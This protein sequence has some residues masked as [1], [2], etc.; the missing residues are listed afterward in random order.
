MARLRRSPLLLGLSLAWAGCSSGKQTGAECANDRDCPAK[1]QRCTAGACVAVPGA[2]CDADADCGAPGFCQI[3]AGAE[4][5]GGLCHYLP[6]NV[7]VSCDDANPCTLDDACDGSGRCTGALT[8]CTTPPPAECVG[9]NDTFRQYTSPGSCDPTDGECDYSYTDSA[10]INCAHDCLDPCAEIVCDDTAGGCRLSAGL[11]DPIPDPV[12]CDYSGS[13]AATDD[14]PCLRPGDLVPGGHC[15]AGEC[16]DCT[17]DL[18]CVT[19][20]GDPDCYA[21]ECTAPFCT[22]TPLAEATVCQPAGCADGAIFVERT[23]GPNRTCPGAEPVSCNGFACADASS[24]ATTCSAASGCLPDYFCNDPTAGDACLP[25]QLDGGSCAGYGDVACLSDHCGGGLCCASGYCCLTGAECWVLV[26]IE[27]YCSAPATC[28]GE[29]TQVACTDFICN[30]TAVGDDSFCAGM[31]AADCGAFRDLFCDLAPEQPTPVC[32]TDC[33]GDNAACDD[34]FYCDGA[35]QCAAQLP[36][37]GVSCDEDGDCA[38]THCDLSAAGSE[39]GRCCATTECCDADADCPAGDQCV[40]QLDGAAVYRCYAGANGDPCDDGTDCDAGV[41][42]TSGVCGTLLANGATGC[43]ANVDCASGHCDLSTGGAETGR[44]CLAG[45]C[46]AADAACPAGWQCVDQL[47][48]ALVYR[49]FNGETSASCDDDDDCDAGYHCRES[50]DLCQSGTIGQGCDDAT[51]CDAGA[52]CS[53][54]SICTAQLAVG[55]TT[56]SAAAQCSSNYCDLSSTGPETGR[57]CGGGQCCDADADCPSGDQCVDLV[58]STATYGCLTGADGQAC[59]D[60]A[61]CDVGNHCRESTN[62]CV[63]GQP[64]HGCDDDADCDSPY[65]CHTNL[66]CGSK[67]S[68]G[69]TPCV[70]DSQ[71]SSGHCDQSTVQPE[72]GRCC[73]GECCDE[74]TDCT[75]GYRCVEGIDGAPLNLCLSGGVGVW[76]DI[77]ADCWSPNLCRESTNVCV[78][79]DLGSPCDDEGD[80]GE[81]LWCED[82]ACQIMLSMGS[83][84]CSQNEGCHTGYCDLSTVGSERYRCCGGGECCDVYG[85][86]PSGYHCIVTAGGVEYYRCYA[87]VTGSPCNTTYGDGNCDPGYHCRASTDRCVSG[88]NGSGCDDNLDCDSGLSCTGGTCG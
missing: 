62:L 4:C 36:D 27:G 69:G 18:H 86:C 71:C 20:P 76:C 61:D 5:Y 58:D 87:G 65:V 66:Q 79:G 30:L 67:L 29:R 32:P 75:A 49:C 43:A 85:D 48:G 7:G 68:T 8:P 63:T 40:D 82:N 22:Y 45:E 57:C 37:G 70:R 34:G 53:A 83:T 73:T 77:D 56:C 54:A 15:F 31:L 11:C 19:P 28:T 44:C 52:Y 33:G 26:P 23:C 3:L 78:D 38:G 2:Q 42:N 25:K 50:I 12:V 59:D 13:T 47:D 72:T 10:C 81:N 64:T 14:T 17:S 74:P 6:G 46:C 24:C 41:C 60:D 55:A 1:S 21:G 80:C 35:G 9:S 16:G 84:G 51:D 39:T 88:G